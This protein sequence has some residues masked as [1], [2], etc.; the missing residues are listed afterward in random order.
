MI[1]CLAKLK[2]NHPCLDSWIDWSRRVKTAVFVAKC[3][4]P[5][6]DVTLDAN[7]GV[8]RIMCVQLVQLNKNESYGWIIYGTWVASETRM[9]PLQANGG[10]GPF[11]M[12]AWGD[13]EPKVSQ[14]NIPTQ[15]NTRNK[16]TNNNKDKKSP[17]ELPPKN[18]QKIPICDVLEPMRLLQ[19][20]STWARRLESQG[21]AQLA[22]PWSGIS[23]RVARCSH[24]VA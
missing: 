8:G 24:L 22:V 21:A 2:G 4:W 19:M 16:I 1:I 7:D 10:N 15:Q 17:T 20:P 9:F 3:G 6:C 14:V 12:T 11:S 18:H 13:A 23:V 5:A